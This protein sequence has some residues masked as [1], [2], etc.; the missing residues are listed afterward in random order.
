[1][2]IHQVF[3]I[4]RFQPDS[5]CPV[6]EHEKKNYYISEIQDAQRLEYQSHSAFIAAVEFARN[7]TPRDLFVRTAH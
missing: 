2:F 6:Q 7:V 3:V 1:V 4:S 5:K